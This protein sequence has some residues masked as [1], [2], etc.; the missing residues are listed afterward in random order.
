MFYVVVDRLSNYPFQRFWIIQPQYLQSHRNDRHLNQCG[1]VESY[2]YQLFY[3][4]KHTI[5]NCDS[6]II[7]IEKQE[8]KRNRIC[9]NCCCCY[10]KSRFMRK[11][12]F[13]FYYL[14]S[15]EKCENS[16]TI[17]WKKTCLNSNE[18][19]MIKDK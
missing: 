19:N 8:T 5:I 3:V 17:I 1:E 18:I 13:F 14:M 7:Q 4:R 9:K 6:L 2:C 16:I 15:R 11:E 12:I 10:C